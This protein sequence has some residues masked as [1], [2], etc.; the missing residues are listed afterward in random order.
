M[1][2]KENLKFFLHF[3]SRLRNVAPT[4]YGMSVTICGREP[5]RQTQRTRVGVK[6]MKI[7]EEMMNNDE[8]KSPKIQAAQNEW[9]VT[10]QKW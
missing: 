4:Y 6:E 5:V 1:F 2:C 3:C 7:N 10:S 8:I 9:K